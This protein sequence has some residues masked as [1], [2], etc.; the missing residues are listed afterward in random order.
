MPDPF[1]EAEKRSK[2]KTKSTPGTFD[3]FGAAAEKMGMETKPGEPPHPRV[4]GEAALRAIPYAAGAAA[5]LATGGMGFIPAVAANAAA[6]AGGSLIESGIR[7]MT[8]M[9]PPESV[10]GAAKDAGIEAGLAEGGGRAVL[11][12]LNKT[13]GKY[14][15]SKR[16]YQ[17]A[18]KPAGTAQ[19]KAGQVVETGMKEGLTL[20]GG[21]APA[22][23]EANRRITQLN[24]AVNR[25]IQNTPADIPPS[26]YV[27]TV[28]N[29]LDTLRKRWSNAGT[30]GRQFVEQI[31]EMERD[32]LISHGNVQPI[33]VQ[34]H[35]P[36]AGYTPGTQMQT[37]TLNP[38]DMS[39]VELRRNARP[40]QT[41]DAQEIKKATY[42]KIR[43]GGQTAWDK[44][45]HPALGKRIDKEIAA[46]L[47][48]E[49]EHVYPQL[50]GLN[51][52][53]GNL[54][55]LERQL[56]RFAKRELNKQATPYFIFPAVGHGLAEESAKPSL[57][58]LAAHLTRSMLEDPGV[59]SRLAIALH[60]V[61]N[62]TVGKAGKVVGKQIPGGVIRVGE[63]L[64]NNQ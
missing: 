47:R 33:Q 30:Q 58:M 27:A 12:V 57:T 23:A 29:K 51:Q 39:L 55:E 42:E 6:G 7:K 2:G 48:E 11:G 14:L 3:P 34:V 52:R 43:T 10:L 26:R 5:G 20:E 38:E 1:G 45:A 63:Y 56:Q 41:G 54:I 36:Q 25:T 50:K 16:L 28:Q 53:E 61:G 31:D 8:G 37:V 17:S 59:K 24:D 21:G 19:G 44:Y 49:L 13:V 60:G 64:S 22:I 15:D 32:F 9:H 46:G 4:Y 35:N 40:M 62:S 18:L